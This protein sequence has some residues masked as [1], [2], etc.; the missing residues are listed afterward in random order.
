M[1]SRP[2][3]VLDEAH[4]HAP[5]LRCARGREEGSDSSRG[6]VAA[7]GGFPLRMDRAT[8]RA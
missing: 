4:R 1:P 7:L 2:V 3:V 5:V 8:P 6:R